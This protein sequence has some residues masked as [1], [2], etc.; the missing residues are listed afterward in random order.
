MKTVKKV[1]WTN[2]NNLPIPNTNLLKE[3]DYVRIVMNI[4]RFQKEATPGWSKEIFQV[5]TLLSTSPPTYTIW[6]LNQETLK[7]TFY[8]EELQKVKLP[9]SDT[10]KIEKI[11]KRR[12]KN[13]N[14]EVFVKW[15]GYPD[16]F[17]T[18]IKAREL[19][20]I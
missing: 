1:W 13:K 12:G 4:K 18:W 19:H 16:S 9:S 6:D 15:E 14:R 10:Y 17:N 3:G 11:L 2:Y 7:G 5:K 20:S 8:R